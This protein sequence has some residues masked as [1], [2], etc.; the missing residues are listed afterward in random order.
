MNIYDSPMVQDGRQ[1]DIVDEVTDSVTYL[2]FLNNGDLSQALICKI[3]KIGDVTT[4]K[5]ADGNLI[6]DADWN[7]RGNLTYLFKR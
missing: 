7:N 6:A 3:E 5:Y 4:R 2:G 1:P